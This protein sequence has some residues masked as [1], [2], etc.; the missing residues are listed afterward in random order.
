MG[1]LIAVGSADRLFFF[2]YEKL[3][4]N[5]RESTKIKYCLLYL[6]MENLKVDRTK[7]ITQSEYAKKVKKTKGAINHMIRDNRIK[8]VEIQG[9][10]LILLD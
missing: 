10:T 2:T 8:Y 3:L 5:L 6:Y 1:K 4:K 7:L 9:A